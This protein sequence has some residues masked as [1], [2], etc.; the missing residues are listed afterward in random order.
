MASF[1]PS[2][3]VALYMGR[4]FVT[5]TFGIL[6]MLVLV[7]QALD[8]LTESSKIVGVPGNGQADV[9]H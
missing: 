5:R 1:F 4:L 3:T 6:A 2:R 8:L 7:L 9:L